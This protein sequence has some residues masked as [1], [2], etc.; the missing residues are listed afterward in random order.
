MYARCKICEF[1]F[2]GNDGKCVV[3]IKTEDGLLSEIEQA[4]VDIFPEHVSPSGF[5]PRGSVVLVGSVS[6]L[7]ARGIASYATDL[8]GIIS[9]LGARAGK[10]VEIIP[11]VLVP[12]GG[13][14][15]KGNGGIWDLLDLDAWIM[16]SGLGPGV[17]L[18]G[19]RWAFWEVVRGWGDLTDPPAWGTGRFSFHPAAETPE[20]APSN[21]RIRIHPSPSVS[22]QWVLRMRGQLSLHS[23][24]T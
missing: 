12:L 9:S 8:V 1:N 16:A 20:S 5:L 10:A 18:E 2:I 4:F 19:A 24:R 11:F 13:T 22:S 3:I 17:R 21:C 23:S 14:G 6:H 7:A 15:G